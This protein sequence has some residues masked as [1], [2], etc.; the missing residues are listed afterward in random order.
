MTTKTTPTTAA[1]NAQEQIAWFEKCIAFEHQWQH[2]LS[3]LI[4]DFWDRPETYERLKQA[5]RDSNARIT[6]YRQKTLRIATGE[7]WLI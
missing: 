5:V 2:D 7:K 3:A 4:P 1:W 6:S